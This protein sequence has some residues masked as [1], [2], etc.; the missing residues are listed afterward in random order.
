MEKLTSLEF[1][2]SISESPEYIKM[3]SKLAEWC[4]VPGTVTGHLGKGIKCNPI[5]EWLLRKS[6]NGE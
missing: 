5:C 3:A 2:P 4:S 1:D 6:R